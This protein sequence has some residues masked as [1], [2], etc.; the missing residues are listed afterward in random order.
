MSWK[1]SD[2]VYQYSEDKA[3]A[4]IFVRSILYI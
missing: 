4:V 2:E 1:D 3:A